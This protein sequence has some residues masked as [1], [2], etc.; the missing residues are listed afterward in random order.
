VAVALA[1]LRERLE[2]LAAPRRAVAPVGQ[3]LMLATLVDQPV[4]G[5]DWL[6]E[7]KYDGVRILAHRA[8]RRVILLGRHGQ[9]FTA[10]YP[11]VVAALGA[12]P[13]EHFL[14]DGEVMALDEAG[15]PSFQQLQARMHLTR[16]ADIERAR[17]TVPV[18]AVFFDA[19]SLDGR[20]LREVPLLERKVC[21]SLALPTRGGAR[22]GDHVL[23]QG[24]AFFAAAC[25]QRLEGIVAK[26]CASRYVG[27]RTRDWLKIKCQLRQE[28]VI[29]GYTDPKGTRSYFGALH[30]G[31]Q[32]NGRLVYVAKVGTGFDAKNLRML[33]DRLGSLARRSSPFDRGSPTGRG[34]H[35]VEPKLVAE[36]RFT[37]W[38]ADGGI[39][40]PA[41]LGLR[42]D[43][44]PEECVRERPAPVTPPGG[45]PGASR[46]RDRSRTPRA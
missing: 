26:R 18:D 28:F 8:G 13:L 19:L 39:R 36:V 5:R 46:T 1:Q 33:W 34:H 40:H 17:A 2:R 12:L 43:K 30:L 3:A 6:F 10:K 23:E 31:L 38:T 11:E 25:Q 29:G 21:L 9:D 27:G 32:E 37:E 35:W 14:L 24:D 7:I 45:R 15:R 4:S 42:D 22:Y 41:F 20:D 16:P 44:R